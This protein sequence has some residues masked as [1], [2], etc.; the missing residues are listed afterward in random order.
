MAST[1]R[2]ENSECNIWGAIYHVINGGDRQ[3]FLV[4]NFCDIVLL[5]EVGS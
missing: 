5:A 1:R 3:I 2:P 4:T